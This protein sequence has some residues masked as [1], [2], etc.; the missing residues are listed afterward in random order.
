MSSWL[1][2]YSEDAEKAKN[3]IKAIDKRKIYVNYANKK[4]DTK[5][6]KSLSS[7]VENEEKQ[8]K[9]PEEEKSEGMCSII[10]CLKVLDIRFF[11]WKQVINQ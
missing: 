5:I 11:S 8:T 1:I 9:E 3:Q 10:F 2:N 6:K 7:K 4:K